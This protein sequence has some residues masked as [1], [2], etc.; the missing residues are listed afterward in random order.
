MLPKL[1]RTEY[2]DEDYP[3]NEQEFKG[4]IATLIHA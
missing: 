2:Y 1:L 3:L 4:V